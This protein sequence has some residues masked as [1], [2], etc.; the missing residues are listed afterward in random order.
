MENNFTFEPV[1]EVSGEIEVTLNKK[2][3]D[4]YEEPL[5]HIVMT[6]GKTG[7]AN[8]LTFNEIESSDVEGIIQTLNKVKDQLKKAE[9]AVE[10]SETESDWKKTETQN[11]IKEYIEQCEEHPTKEDVANYISQTEKLEDIEKEDV[12]SDI[13]ELKIMG[14]IFEPKPEHLQ[15]I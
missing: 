1:S 6:I 4:K 7:R 12:Y 3:H 8:R 13:E 14:E 9:K 2:K 10:K 11:K 15:A 5:E